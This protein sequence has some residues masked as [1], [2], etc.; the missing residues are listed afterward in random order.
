VDVAATEMSILIFVSLN[1]VILP[2]VELGSS[3]AQP[4]KPEVVFI[5]IS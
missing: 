1:R 4:E 2:G 3:V 5:V